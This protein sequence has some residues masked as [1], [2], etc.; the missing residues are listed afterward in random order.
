MVRLRA[1]YKDGGIVPVDDD[2]SSDVQQ[3][4]QPSE[5]ERINSLHI[6]PEAKDWLK[7]H[8]QY[9][10]D[11]EENQKIGAAHSAV[12][13]EGFIQNTPAYFDALEQQLGH[14][15]MVDTVPMPPPPRPRPMPDD[16]YE[17]PARRVTVSAPPSREVPTSDY[18]ASRDGHGRINLSHNQKEAARIS[19]I[20]EADYA[21]QL[22][23]LRGRKEMLGI[24]VVRH[25]G[26]G[27]CWPDNSGQ[28]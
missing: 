18:S 2:V 8:P 22:M 21:K 24:M 16:D 6:A 5:S 13:A 11:A 15:P 4:H 7:R 26:A 28:A 3:Q 19:G 27:V 17:P 10:F 1:Q 12:I 25:D 23:R 9:V 20:S 14:K